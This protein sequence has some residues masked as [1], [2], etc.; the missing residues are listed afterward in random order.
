[1]RRLWRRTRDRIRDDV[2]LWGG[3]RESW[4]GVFLG[5][6]SLF[7]YALRSWVRHKRQ[8]PR[9]FS[10]DPRFVRLRSSEEAGRWLESR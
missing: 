1:M 4:R 8:W 9:R 2:E 6:D 10:G 3:N 7:V 5:W